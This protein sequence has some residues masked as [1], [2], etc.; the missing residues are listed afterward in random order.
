[1]SARLSSGPSR[2]VK[3]LAVCHSTPLTSRIAT[4]SLCAET[5]RLRSGASRCTS[6]IGIPS[7]PIRSD[8]NVAPA[9]NGHGPQDSAAPTLLMSS[10]RGVRQ[11]RRAWLG[12]SRA[13][14]SRTMSSARWKPM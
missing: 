6:A 9:D 14:P 3:P 5:A 12:I 10:E 13:P 2:R 4:A 7:A 11:P 8:S 1:M